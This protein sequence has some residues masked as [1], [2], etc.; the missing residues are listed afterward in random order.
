MFEH[1]DDVEIVPVE[2]MPEDLNI[3]LSKANAIRLNLPEEQVYPWLTFLLD[4]YSIVDASIL[5]AEEQANKA[6]RKLACKEGCAFC[7]Y[8][9][10]PVSPLEAMGIRLAKTA[11]LPRVEREAIQ[12]EL[13]HTKNK[14]NLSNQEKQ[15]CPFLINNSCSIY[16]VRPIACRRFL[17]LDTECSNSQ[18]DVVETRPNDVLHSDRGALYAAYAHTSQVYASLGI[19]E[20]GKTLTFDNFTNLFVDIR[21]IDWLKY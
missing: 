15:K 20:R 4:A 10:V 7:C 2:E 13:E 14:E 6:N 19:T 21:K 18:E 5:Y 1:L 17:M 12:K 3:I 8:Q 16:A 9:E 11:L